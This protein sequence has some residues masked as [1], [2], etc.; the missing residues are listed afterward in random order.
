MLTQAT[1]RNFHAMTQVMI[2]FFPE[3][4]KKATLFTKLHGQSILVGIR[5]AENGTEHLLE[6][7]PIFPREWQ[8]AAPIE[9]IFEVA[10]HCNS[11]TKLSSRDTAELTAL[12][13]IVSATVEAYLNR[14]TLVFKI[15]VEFDLKQTLE[16]SFDVYQITNIVKMAKRFKM[17]IEVEIPEID[18]S[19]NTSSNNTAREVSLEN[20]FSS[21]QLSQIWLAGNSIG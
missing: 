19:S 10:S 9:V 6:N 21:D 1:T 17:Y 16:S 11:K 3:A 12:T 15:S 7:T 18:Y 2:E 8:V 13:E 14:C 20:I 5:C 4:M